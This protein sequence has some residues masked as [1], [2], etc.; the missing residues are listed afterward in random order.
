MITSWLTKCITEHRASCPYDQYAFLPTRLIDVGPSD[1][2]HEPLLRCSERSEKGAW[3]ALS[4]CWGHGPHFTT[5][6]VTIAARKQSINFDDLPKTFQDAV[7]VTRALGYRY[8]W[9]DSLCILQDDGND[10]ASEAAK[11]FSYYRHATLT[12]AVD[13]AAGDNEGFLHK[14]R[15]GAEIVATIPVKWGKK[16]SER[17]KKDK[18][19]SDDRTG[20]PSSQTNPSAPDKLFLR[21]LPTEAEEKAI[22]EQP[23]FKRAWTLQESL[24]SPRMVH[25][26]SEQLVWE[27]QHCTLSESN[28]EPRFSIH[29]DYYY[30]K[31]SFLQPAGD[32]P[33]FQHSVKAVVRQISFKWYCIIAEYTTRAL[34]NPDD[35]LPAIAG[36]AREV[37]RQT[38]WSY[39]AGLWLQDLHRGLVWCYQNGA[40]SPAAFR[41]P[42]FSWA[43]LDEAR[44]EKR[45]TAAGL[46]FHEFL[47][48]QHTMWILNRSKPLA[49]LR[50]CEVLPLD[51]DPY[52]RVKSGYI[53]LSSYWISSSHWCRRISSLFYVNDYGE[54]SKSYIRGSRLDDRFVGDEQVI[55]T[56]D[57][58]PDSQQT[59]DL[60]SGVSFLQIAYWNGWRSIT[61][62]MVLLALMLKETGSHGN[63]VRVG[64][65]EFPF[66]KHDHLQRIPRMC[67]GPPTAADVAATDKAFEE[68]FDKI[69]TEECQYRNPESFDLINWKR[70]E[71]TI[72]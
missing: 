68:S 53:T 62:R 43:A 47:V 38:S 28:V 10:W 50:K 20:D 15:P 59:Q 31:K 42:S 49:V 63:F 25:Y 69:G 1:S 26:S 6:T 5:T 8:I 14:L 72:V 67:T 7:F 65:A 36:I 71:V 19:F 33:R 40:K 46:Y 2:S 24:L 56:F 35:R 39:R 44:P 48:P 57:Q 21:K 61:S 52:G 11:M 70:M 54:G 60:F 18:I 13:A 32:L 30:K 58:P 51:G 37:E 41:A 29:E 23:L 34:T 22:S 45:F 66:P 12:I 64:I 55:C 16:R 27:C 3:L 17:N 4:H 9:I